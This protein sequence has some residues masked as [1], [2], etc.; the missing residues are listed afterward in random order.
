MFFLVA[1]RQPNGDPT[2]DD[3]SAGQGSCKRPTV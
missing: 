1:G 3:R 2:T